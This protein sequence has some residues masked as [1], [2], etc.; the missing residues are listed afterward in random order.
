M[1]VPDG[2]APPASV[3]SGQRSTVELRNQKNGG[4]NET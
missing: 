4:A 2:V 1:V 3:E